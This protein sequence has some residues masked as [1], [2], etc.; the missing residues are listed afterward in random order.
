MLD[1]TCRTLSK[2]LKLESDSTSK[3]K[4]NK[5][6]KGSKVNPKTKSKKNNKGKPAKKDRQARGSKAQSETHPEIDAPVAPK[7]R[8][9]GA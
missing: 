7:R 9:R 4:K 3:P 8:R 1:C 2:D 5:P 6:V